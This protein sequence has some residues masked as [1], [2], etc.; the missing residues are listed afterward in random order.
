MFRLEDLLLMGVVWLHLALDGLAQLGV[1]QPP[2]T[3]TLPYK[4]EVPSKFCPFGQELDH[5]LPRSS[6]GE[7]VSMD[8]SRKFPFFDIPYQ[9][10][11]PNT[12]GAITFDRG[13]ALVSMTLELILEGESIAKN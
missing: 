13:N 4:P 11:F 7:F 6:S 1:T 2:G 8:L 3:Y 10:L 5:L 9:T 12:N